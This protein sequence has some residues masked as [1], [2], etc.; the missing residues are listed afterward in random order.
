MP[1]RSG[2]AL[3]SV[4]WGFQTAAAAPGCFDSKR[5][6]KTRPRTPSNSFQDRCSELW[7][8]NNASEAVLVGH[9]R[10]KPLI[11]ARLVVQVHPGP[12]NAQTK[13]RRLS[14]RKFSLRDRYPNRLAVRYAAVR[15]GIMR[16]AAAALVTARA[17]QISMTR[18]NAKT[19]AWAM[20]S[21]T[22]EEV[23]ASRPA[24]TSRPASLMTLD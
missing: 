1:P 19:N 3:V 23:C 4:T 11:R 18:R 17:A 2:Q 7:I 24:G 15:E 6:R 13:I 22:A 12:P 20:A 8:S 21:C 5:Q 16:E 9:D 14:W 10:P